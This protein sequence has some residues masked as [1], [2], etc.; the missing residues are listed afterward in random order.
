MT[1]RIELRH[2]RGAKD[3]TR[4]CT[5]T[6]VVGRSP[7]RCT[8]RTHVTRLLLSLLLYYCKSITCYIIV[9]LARIVLQTVKF[10]GKLSIIHT[11]DNSN[12]DYNN[13]H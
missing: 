4:S 8:Y 3:T 11:D 9:P 2:K 6:V 13:N 7:L 1:V 10:A 12:T 5:V